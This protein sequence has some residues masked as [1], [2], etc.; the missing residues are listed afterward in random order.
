MCGSRALGKQSWLGCIASAT[1]QQV[2]EEEC[3]STDSRMVCI[4]EITTVFLL[5]SLQAMAGSRREREREREGERRL[6]PWYHV[7]WDEPQSSDQYQTEVRSALDSG[8][9]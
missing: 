2:M 7:R 1:G 6:R 4:V 9:H 3:I 5:D 8:L